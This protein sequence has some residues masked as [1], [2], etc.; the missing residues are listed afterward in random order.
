MLK[1]MLP[2]SRR[3]EGSGLMLRNVRGSEGTRNGISRDSIDVS[4]SQ[5]PREPTERLTGG[6]DSVCV[7]VVT[8]LD[9]S[10]E[11]PEVGEVVDVEVE[12]IA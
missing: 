3:A 4:T 12:V 6:S 5:Q 9:C 7:P 2:A 11:H 10:G 1:L 8:Q